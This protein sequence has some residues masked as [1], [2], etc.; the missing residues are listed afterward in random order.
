MIAVG[1][2]PRIIDSEPRII[3]SGLAATFSW[4]TDGK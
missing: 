1:F 4:T 3:D 2:Q